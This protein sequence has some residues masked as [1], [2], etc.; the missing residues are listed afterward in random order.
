MRPDCFSPGISLRISRYTHPLDASLWRLYWVMISSGIMSRLIYIYS[1]RALGVLYWN[2]L[3]SRVKT[4]AQGMEMV[5]FK[6]HLVVV[7]LAQLVVVLPGKSNL[8]PPTVT[9]TRCVSVLWDRML[10]SYRPIGVL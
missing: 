3:I 7:K 2:F 4:R 8:L 9:R 6:R 5:L 1:Y 10:F